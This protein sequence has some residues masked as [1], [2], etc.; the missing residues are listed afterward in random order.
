MSVLGGS[1]VRI[2][3][4]T[5]LGHFQA[6]PSPLESVP[7][8]AG[9]YLQ[10]HMKALLLDRLWGHLGL[11]GIWPDVC[12]YVCVAGERR[13]ENKGTIYSFNRYLLRTEV[14]STGKGTVDIVMTTRTVG[15][16]NEITTVNMQCV[17]CCR[18]K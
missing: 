9:S 17:K 4:P 5:I 15:N 11:L 16:N 18:K 14:L 3:K 7:T 10:V 2:P 12:V 13:R 1:K 6:P 8:S